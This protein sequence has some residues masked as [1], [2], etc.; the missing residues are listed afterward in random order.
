MS[1]GLGP[2]RA[3]GAVPDALEEIGGSVSS[4]L[5]Q[6]VWSASGA[7]QA[8]KVAEAE[9]QEAIRRRDHFLAHP[10]PRAAQPAGRLVNAARLLEDDDLDDEALEIARG[11]IIRQSG[12]MTRLLDDLLDVAGYPRQDRDP[13]AGDRPAPSRAGCPGGAALP[14]LDAKDVHLSI[15]MPDEPLC[16]HG[17]PAR[18]QQIQVIL[19]LNNAIKYTPARGRIWLSLTREGGTAVLSVRDTGVGIPEAM[20]IFFICSSSWTA[21]RAVPAAAWASVSPWC[22]PWYGFMAARSSSRAA[23][24]MAGAASF[25]SESRRSTRK[26]QHPPQ[27]RQTAAVG[28]AGT[29]G[30]R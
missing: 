24:A 13:Q 11:A 6:C 16:V 8:R 5:A 9:A 25:W 20:S 22:D 14:Q 7:E 15:M 19:L 1:W 4:E 12:Q 30:G 23:R 28:S 2:G 21:H 27:D 10:R 26:A 3:A 17:D 18:L 29:A